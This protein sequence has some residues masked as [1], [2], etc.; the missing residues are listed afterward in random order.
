[1]DCWRHRLIPSSKLQVRCFVL[2]P[3]MKHSVAQGSPFLWIKKMWA[4]G[5][6]PGYHPKDD[7]R[8]FHPDAVCVKKHSICNIVGYVVYMSA[9]DAKADIRP[10]ASA[11]NAKDAWSKALS[12]LFKY[13]FVN[14]VYIPI[15]EDKS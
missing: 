5:P 10:I 2:C 13:D 3:R 8:S 11:G 9:A 4:K 12:K 14:N 15:P 1:M 6:M 7:F